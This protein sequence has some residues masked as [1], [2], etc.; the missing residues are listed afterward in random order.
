MVVVSLV[1]RWVISQLPIGTVDTK[2][3][4]A[5]AVPHLGEVSSLASSAECPHNP[6]TQRRADR[7]KLLIL[8]NEY[9][10]SNYQVPG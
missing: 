8:F 7:Q 6:T 9:V 4:M 3:E 2:S 1:L 5:S 10:L